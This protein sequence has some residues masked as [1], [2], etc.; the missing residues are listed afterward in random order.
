MNTVLLF[1][2]VAVW[3]AYNVP[4]ALKFGIQSSV[5]STYN[6]FK[7]IWGKSLLSWFIAGIGISLM[8]VANNS[9]GVLSGMFLLLIFAAPTVRA[10][11][12]AEILHT[13]GAWGGIIAGMASIII[14]NLWLIPLVILFFVFT[15]YS[16][17]KGYKNHTYWIETIAFFVIIIGLFISKI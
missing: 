15:I 14:I 16:M 2:A 11:R 1:F 5:S 12:I 8:I 4:V 7:T 6:C 9:M 13:T 17:I 3:L 10:G